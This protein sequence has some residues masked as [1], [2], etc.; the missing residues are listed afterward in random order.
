MEADMDRILA[1]LLALLVIAC[2]D[3]PAANGFG[4]LGP[5]VSENVGTA[6]AHRAP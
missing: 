1:I 3:T 6:A 5:S 2:T 4:G